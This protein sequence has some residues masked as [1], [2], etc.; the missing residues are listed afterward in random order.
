MLKIATQIMSKYLPIP[1]IAFPKAVAVKLTPLVSLV[2]QTPVTNMANAV[3]VH[4]MI[5]SINGPNIATN[6]SLIGSSVFAAP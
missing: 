1:G 4:T 5:V 3:S 6:P 2:C